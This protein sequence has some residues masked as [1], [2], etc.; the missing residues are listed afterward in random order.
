MTAT[1]WFLFGLWTGCCT[2]LLLSACVFMAREEQQHA[3][4]AL[5]K[6][7]GAP[8]RTAPRKSRVSMNL[9]RLKNGYAD[10]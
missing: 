6:L 8:S 7:R 9:L 3:N 5:T 2:G 10:I 1:L 4:A